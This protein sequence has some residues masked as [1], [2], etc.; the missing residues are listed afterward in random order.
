MPG[1][2]FTFQPWI[3]SSVKKS[4][5]LIHHAAEG[6]PADSS[7]HAF[8]IKR[9]EIAY[10]MSERTFSFLLNDFDLDP[11]GSFHLLTLYP[12][13]STSERVYKD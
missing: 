3:L 7:L 1:H 13:V 2:I 4:M 9:G 12:C 8:P 11:I 10:P 5:D 6:M